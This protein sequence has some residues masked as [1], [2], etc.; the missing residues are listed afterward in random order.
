LNQ[1]LQRTLAQAPLTPYTLTAIAVCVGL[2]MVDGFDVLTMSFAAS[3]V[4]AD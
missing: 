3:G 2:N 4:K 1:D